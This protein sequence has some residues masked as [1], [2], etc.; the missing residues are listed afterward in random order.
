M[1]FRTYKAELY[2]DQPYG[3][4]EVAVQMLLDRDADIKAMVSETSAEAETSSHA[5]ADI[6]SDTETSSNAETS[7]VA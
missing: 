4:L 5:G 1:T 6:S 3:I 2:R 7:S